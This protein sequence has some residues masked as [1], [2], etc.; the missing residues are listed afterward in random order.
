MA[1]E[2]GKIVRRINPSFTQTHVPV[3]ALSGGQRQTV[4]I[5]RAL[6]FDAKILIMD[7]PTAALGPG[8]TRMVK[9]IIRGLKRDGIGIFIVSHE[10]RDVFDVCDRLVVLKNG[11]LV[12]TT[13]VSDVTEEDVL[14]MI[15]LGKAPPPRE[16]GASTAGSSAGR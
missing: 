11:K 7:E 1:H 14:G 13:K 9:D 2:A 8:E 10:M 15:I 4:A 3:R 16:A 5:A 6:Y 12:G